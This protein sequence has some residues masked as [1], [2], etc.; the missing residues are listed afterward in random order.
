MGWP[1]PP[2]GSDGSSEFE[3]ARYQAELD[4]ELALRREE[5]ANDAA[6][7]QLRRDLQKTAQD[8]EDALGKSVHDARLEVAKAAIDRGIGGAEFV[9]NAAAAIVTLYTGLLGV[10]YAT[11]ENATPLPARGIAP[12]V[13]LGLALACATAY[14]A[15]LS[16]TPS[17]AAPRPHSDLATYQERRLNVFIGWASDIAMGRA[18]FLHASVFAMFFGILLLPV[19]FIDIS[20]GLVTFV[21]IVFFLA[22]L[23]LPRRTAG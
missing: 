10:T 20:D 8:A 22:S 2:S 1:D 21:G 14:A 23:L 15:L 5:A 16:Q 3:K 17:A 9:R 19:P 13:L 6:D 4:D 12:A 11:A 7:A 18:Y